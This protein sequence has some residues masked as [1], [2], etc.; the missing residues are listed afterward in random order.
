MILQ[1]LAEQ[2]E[3]LLAD[4]ESGVAPPGYSPAKV[5]HA[6]VLNAEG[7]LVDVLPLGTNQG[8][9]VLPQIILVPEQEKRASGIS[10]NLLCDNSGY[11]LGIKK[12]KQGELVAAA[13]KFNAFQERNKSLLKEV[14]SPSAKAVVAFLQGW[15]GDEHL[16]QP[17][18]QAWLEAVTNGSNL[19]FK[20]DGQRGYVHEEAEVRAAWAKSRQNGEKGVVGQCLLTGERLPIARIHPS[21][22]GVIGAQ[23]S[24]A[25]IVS[26]N[27]DSFISYGKTQSYNAPVGETTAFAYATALNYLTAS[28]RNRVRLADTTMV[29]WADKAQGKREESL[30]SWWL[31]PV[32][33]DAEQSDARQLAPEVVAQAKTVL[34]RVKQGLPAGESGFSCETRCCLLGLAPNAAR[35]SVRF[36]Q[37]NSFGEVLKRIG[38]HYLDLEI[39]G[40]ERY[41]TAIAPWRILKELAVQRDSKNIPPLL[42]GQLMQSILSGQAYPQTLYAAALGR[43]R[44]GGDHG[45]VTAI[46]AAVIK[47]CLVRKYRIQKQFQKEAWITVSLDAKNTMPAYLLGRLFSVLEKAQ[48]DALGGG[49]NAT[50][51]DRYFGA[52]SATPGAVFPLLL[53]LSRHHLNKAQY[54]MHLDRKIQG[55][56]GL[57]DANPFPAHL[58]MEA[59]GLFILGYYHQN[60]A[61]YEKSETQE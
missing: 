54:G 41:G 15:R 60:Q 18:Y 58:N 40:L 23:T 36:W 57:L 1:A 8:K 35:L 61:N 4:P 38:Q 28:A 51:R 56:L 45:G 29:F 13:A 2:Y 32:D 17:E 48:K 5:S 19:V 21:I 26:F 34:A 10:A 55:I 47:A 37:V 6:L 49:I 30:L 27:I 33:D 9:K 44:T 20:I 25:A 11:V 43:C 50:I 12:N 7:E 14:K 46:R 42:G 53:R 39:A 31:E 22:K 16:N 59:Q 24:G 3:R 52:A